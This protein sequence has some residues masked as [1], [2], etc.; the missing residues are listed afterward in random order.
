M[1]AE[2]TGKKL[3]K[4][5]RCQATRRSLNWRNE[6]ENRKKI[7]SARQRI[8]WQR[9]GSLQESETAHGGEQEGGTKSP[10]ENGPK[11][12]REEVAVQGSTLKSR[13]GKAFRETAMG[14]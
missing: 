13:G 1:E 3:V 14:P 11:G 7:P 12:G 5:A 6:S 2:K 9:Q 8:R 10:V 4:Q